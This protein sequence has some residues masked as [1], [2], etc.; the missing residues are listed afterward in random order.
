[1]AIITVPLVAESLSRIRPVTMVT[2]TGFPEFASCHIF[3]KRCVSRVNPR[4]GKTVFGLEYRQSHFKAKPATIILLSALSEQFRHQDV[5]GL[6]STHCE[7]PSDVWCVH[8]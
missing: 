8:R 7:S 4:V 1:M 3:N 2:V 5:R 6:L